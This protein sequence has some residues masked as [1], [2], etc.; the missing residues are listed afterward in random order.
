VVTVVAVSLDAFL[1]ARY[2]C[3]MSQ[4]AS[5]P[6]KPRRPGQCR[7]LMP[8]G[9]PPDRLIV[10]QAAEEHYV[11][12]DQAGLRLDQFLK[13]KLRWRSRTKVQEL[14]EQREVTS[15]GV[16]L[17][18]SYRVKTA[19]MV[20]V[21]L[22]PAPADARERMAEIPLEILYEDD[23]LIVLNK[24]PN[25]VVHPAGKHHYDTIINA[26]HLRYRNL[27]DHRK[28]VVP[29][30]AHRIDKDT[31]GVLVVCKTGRNDRSVPL[32]FEQSDVTKEY[33]AIAEGVI[34]KDEGIIDLRLGREDHENAN[35]A[36]MR[37]REDG[38]EA[39]TGF[40][41]VERFAA[42]TLVR[43][44]LYTGRMHQIR[45]HLKAI[46][47]PILCDK[48]Y[49]VRSKLYLSDLRAMSHRMEEGVSGSPVRRGKACLAPTTKKD[50]AWPDKGAACCAPTA[51]AD[52]K[53]VEHGSED[54]LLLD[55][56]A[57]HAARITFKHPATK[58]PLT[59]EAPLP[60]DMRR[61]LEALRTA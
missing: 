27:E 55:R 32:I 35:L 48:V 47:H 28:D 54:V 46:G 49:G 1:P 61:T 11:Y 52:A 44:R 15:A 40:K 17:D 7:Q 25:V 6:T 56:Q 12:P 20:R 21:P 58:Q 29:K 42:F 50:S 36:Q 60:E 53:Q 59:V 4:S 38:Q 37:V 3:A 30:L 31:S 19:E 5:Q 23:L 9:K 14:I 57:L 45:V 43:C 22:P 39:R 41:V 16:R 13:L 18:C 10:P 24:Q 26:L 51:G 34:E 33:L 2:L 8:H